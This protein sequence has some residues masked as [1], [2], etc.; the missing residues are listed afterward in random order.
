MADCGNG[1]AERGAGDPTTDV[2]ERPLGHRPARYSDLPFVDAIT[3]SAFAYYDD[4]LCSLR[5]LVEITDVCEQELKGLL[6]DVCGPAWQS[7]GG[8]STQLFELAC[9]VDRRAVCLHKDRVVGSQPG[10]DPI[11]WTTR[12]GHTYAYADHSV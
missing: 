6:T 2:R 8:T 3:P 10:P 11:V 12:E 4:K 9:L 5:Q 1:D 7:K